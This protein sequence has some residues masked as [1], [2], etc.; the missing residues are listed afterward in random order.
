VVPDKNRNPEEVKAREREAPVSLAPVPYEG[1]VAD[2]LKVK[3]PEREDK[4][5]KARPRERKKRNV[6]PRGSV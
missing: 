5:K 1:A 4:P 6:D 2:R 3:K